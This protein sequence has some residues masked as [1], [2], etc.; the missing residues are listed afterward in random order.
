MVLVVLGYVLLIATLGYSLV[1]CCVA[2]AWRR[3][4]PGW[5]DGTEPVSLLK[6]LCGAEPGL[7]ERLRSFC[8]QDHPAVQL[9][10]GVNDPHDPALRVV[11]R[12]RREFP[13]LDIA[14]VVAGGQGGGNPKVA[15]LRNML[16]AA[17][18]PRLILSDSDVRVSP[19]YARTVSAPL[20]DARV[21][22][23]T[24]LY[25]AAPQRGLW[26]RLGADF[27]NGWF[28][29]S[30]LLEWRLGQSAPAFGATMAM[31]RETLD[32]IG[33]FGAVAGYL[34]DDYVLGQRVAE[35]G[36]RCVLSPCVVETAVA[37]DDAV[38]LWRHELRWMRTFRSLRPLGHTL[39]PLS[40]G[41][42]LMLAGLLLAGLT[43]P[44][45][46]LC[47]AAVLARASLP[48]ALQHLFP[49]RE[50]QGFARSW[51]LLMP[52]RDAFSLAVWCTSMLTR[53]VYWRG[54]RYTV[55]PGGKLTQ[56][57]R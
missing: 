49:E 53:T 12:L 6:P 32:A 37:E 14:V 54:H 46:T 28:I 17:R 38:A 52:L 1:A 22:L 9:V 3:R 30:A 8:V 13:A 21:G 25:R 55:R 47:A 23:V 2:F 31:R 7:H 51:P 48:L 56:S 10:F 11:A 19:D 5:R 34:A 16:S 44:A 29:P 15:N 36:L 42:P 33:G 43:A 18:Y 4:A 57:L 45:V 27:I 40:L 20:G 41:L 24:C 35:R 39:V 50:W 26:S